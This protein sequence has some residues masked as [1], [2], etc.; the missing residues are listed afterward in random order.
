VGELEDFVPVLAEK[1]LQEGTM[2]LLSVEGT[3]VY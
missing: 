2:K 3:P 1:E